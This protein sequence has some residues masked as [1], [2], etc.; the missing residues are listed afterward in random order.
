MKTVIFSPFGAASEETGLL[1]LLGNYLKN[2]IPEICVLRCNGVFSLCD[3]DSE[4]SWRRGIHGCFVCMQEQGRLAAWAGLRQEDL[5]LYLT[6]QQITES[7]RWALSLAADEME[8]AVFG[9]IKPYSL[10]R[11]SLRNYFGNLE[12]DLSNANHLHIVR[13]MMISAVRMCQAAD[14]FISAAK[15]TLALVAGGED[16][17][18]GAL[19]ERSRVK[20]VDVAEFRWDL[21]N[22]S[23]KIFHPRLQK[24]FSCPL[25]FED[26]TSM[27]SDSRTW[28][29]ELVRIVEDILVFLD[30][31]SSQLVLPI[32]R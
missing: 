17:I 15:P 3:R 5:S 1:G 25:V 4:N 26:I 29:W 14:C 18:S 12:P 11:A 13:R 20:G 23:V 24:E 30:L 8:E 28:P 27:R 21:P 32:A 2:I 7:K 31:T 6:P 19:A 22:R 16:F 9:Q 10:C